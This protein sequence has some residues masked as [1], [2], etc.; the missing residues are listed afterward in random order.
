MLGLEQS[1]SLSYW[2]IVFTDSIDC[3]TIRLSHYHP[4]S[5]SEVVF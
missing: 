1:L 4:N 2:S 5:S 3:W